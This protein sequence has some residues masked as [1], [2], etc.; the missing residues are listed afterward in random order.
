MEGVGE[1]HTTPPFP[2]LEDARSLKTRSAMTA[3]RVDITNVEPLASRL[4]ANAPGPQLRFAFFCARMLAAS[5]SPLQAGGTGREPPLRAHCALGASTTHHAVIS[6]K[7]LSQRKTARLR[8]G[9][10]VGVV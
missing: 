4:G 8:V 1:L 7:P 3:L 2:Q 5:S 10:K 9:G 6:N